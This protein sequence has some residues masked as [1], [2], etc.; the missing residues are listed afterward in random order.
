MG[1]TEDT[2]S[3]LESERIKLWEEISSI[4]EKINLLDIE[5]KKAQDLAE[6]KISTDETIA[7]EAARS[8]SDSATSSKEK[9]NEILAFYTEIKETYDIY[10]KN[11]SSLNNIIRKIENVKKT[12]DLISEEQARL[13]E[14]QE[15]I[16]RTYN[17]TTSTSSKINDIVERINESELNVKSA[18]TKIN[19]L[20]VKSSELK[21][22][23][24]N[25]FDDVMGYDY[26]DENTGEEQH[27]KGLKKELEES[28]DEL[29]KSIK[30]QKEELLN[31]IDIN[32][33]NF[34][35]LKESYDTVFNERK[36][37]IDSLLP[38]ALTAGLSSAYEKKKN[39]EIENFAMNRIRFNWAIAALVVISVI[40]VAIDAVLYF[41]FDYSFISI[42]ENLPK[43]L[44]FSIPIYLPVL[45]FALN[46]N[47]EMKLSRRL[48]EEYAH[49]EVLAKTYQGLDKQI[50][51]LDNN[52]NILNLK[53][54]LL[55]NMVS[56]SAEN[57]GK[58]ITDYNKTDNP[59]FEILDRSAALSE[60]FD[61]LKNI[62][63]FDKIASYYKSQEKAEKEIA[64]KKVE[65]GIDVARS[66]NEDR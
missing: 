16:Q 54:K 5:T 45:W 19:D 7:K 59:I 8:A 11:K 6:N 46:A 40:P 42:V 37:K 62:P 25:A 50:K 33:S 13:S 60:T 12:F 14:L 56:A 55:H 28:F 24:N 20:L 44:S 22:E 34:N 36:S 31:F 43:L 9:L 63:G 57:P 27:E 26:E 17:T 64:N 66:V 58:L 2:I 3:Y 4:R 15:E 18:S 49:K 52:D 1:Q 35:E 38:D 30:N 10:N 39:D 21:K 48:I 29:S 32:K 51:S 23:I 53:S 65:D 47:K 41:K 61:K